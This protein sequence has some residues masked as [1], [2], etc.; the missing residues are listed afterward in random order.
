MNPEHSSCCEKAGQQTAA[1]KE[2]HEIDVING[3]AWAERAREAERERDALRAVAK[4]A[5][6]F[7]QPRES[8]SHPGSGGD[9]AALKRLHALQVALAR[10]AIV[11]ALNALARAGCK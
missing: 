2:A 7:I 6:E 1:L 8:G 3:E 10:P 4:A 11:K 5:E 9:P